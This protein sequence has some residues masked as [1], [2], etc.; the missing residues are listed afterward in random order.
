MKRIFFVLT[1]IAGLLSADRLLAQDILKKEPKKDHKHDILTISNKG[2]KIE[3]GDSTHKHVLENQEENQFTSSFLLFDLGVNMLQDNTNYLATVNSLLPPGPGATFGTTG[4]NM[5]DLRTAKSIN[6]NIYP[7]M[8]KFR[9]LKTPGQRIYVSAG[10]GLQIYNFRFENATI[11][12]RNPTYIFVDNSKTFKKNKLAVNY[13]SV[14]LMLTF[15]TRLH[16]DPGGKS[17]KDTW[18]VYGAGITEGLRLNSWTKQ[19]SDVFGKVKVHDQFGLADFNTC[20]TAEF[21][22]E[23]II[24]FFASYQLTNL[25]QTSMGLDQHPFSVGIRL[26]GI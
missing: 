23:G 3:Q 1:I 26:S 25:Y 6:V 17:K 11:F 21:G 22:V 19:K 20:V 2:I 10:L 18:L 7:F 15:K 8:E 9:A 13:L 12:T 4:R 14:P 24:R 16:K 5:F